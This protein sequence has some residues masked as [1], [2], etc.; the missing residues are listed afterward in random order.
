MLPG[1]AFTGLLVDFLG[2]FSLSGTMMGKVNYRYVTTGL[3][4]FTF[5]VVCVTMLALVAAPARAV[6]LLR[7]PDIENALNQI[8]RPILNAAGLGSNVRVLVV[9]DSSLNAFVVDTQHIFIHSGLLL[10]M[11]NADMLQAVIAH[12][13]AH[14][15]NGHLARRHQNIGTAKTVAGLGIALSA[16]AAAATGNS[17]AAAGAAF[18]IT[19]SAQRVFL[20]HTRAEEA[21]AD[22]SGL[23]YMV[24]AGADTQGAVD[25]FELF[26]G[27]E[28]LKNS[29]QD[30]YVR[31][32]PLTRDRLRSAK[33]AAD[34]Y[35]GKA[36]PDA[37]KAY[38]F[39]RA[40]GK[41]S[42]FIRNPKWTIG[43]LKDSP[44]EDVRLMREAVALHRQSKTSKA[45]ATLDK[46][47]ALRPGDPY[48]YELRGQFLI[49]SR[50][51]R[52]AAASYKRCVDRLSGN[53]LCLGSYGRALL[54]AGDARSALGALEK[55]RSLDFRDSRILRDLASAYAQTGNPGMA[56]V[57]AAERYALQGRMKDAGIQANRAAGLLPE[58]SG[59]WR[60]AQDIISAAKRAEKKK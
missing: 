48:Y 35:A 54:A 46:A 24:R 44:S 1:P 21:S 18:G 6:S 26:R 4:Q 39:G 14:I 53:A 42:A 8:A 28:L 34:A 38:W 29:R 50:D 5:G 13:A 7:D 31:S 59:G 36:L 23:S 9:H 20:S 15:A 51:A 32:H 52:G 49:E 22:K 57:A 37:A 11:E 19:N 40:K 16:I 12:E 30:P 56:S 2:D 3:R 27:Q 60:R 58:G 17:E 33:A 45:V 47:L 25:V 55:A 41:L 10:R 43:R